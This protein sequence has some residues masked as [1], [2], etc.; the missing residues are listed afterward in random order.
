MKYLVLLLVVLG[1]VWLWRSRRQEDADERAAD[2]ARARAAEAPPLLPM[3]ACPVC[4]L[5]LPENDAVPGRLARYC[6]TAHR[7]QAE[8]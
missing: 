1:G 3:V 6:S 8:P 4:G 5:H 2:K 7:Q